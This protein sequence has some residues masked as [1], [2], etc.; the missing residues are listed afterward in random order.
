M[1]MYLRNRQVNMHANAIGSDNIFKML[2]LKDKF[3]AP[4]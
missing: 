4:G 2:Y 3:I 1:Q